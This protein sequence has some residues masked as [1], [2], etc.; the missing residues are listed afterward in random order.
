MRNR[1]KRKLLVTRVDAGQTPPLS[2]RSRTRDWD[3][4]I[5]NITTKARF[6]IAH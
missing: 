2:G 6:A 1:L 5:K 4:A 3:D